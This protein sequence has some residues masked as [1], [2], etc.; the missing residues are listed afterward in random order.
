MSPGITSASTPWGGG[1]IA[2]QY[3]SHRDSNEHSARAGLHHR[4]CVG[5]GSSVLG[6][7]PLV[8]L[9]YIICL[10]VPPSRQKRS[11]QI[12]HTG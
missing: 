7:S 6:A 4:K 5:A 9:V 10:S 8:F 1:D 2:G 12:Q 3:P 11:C